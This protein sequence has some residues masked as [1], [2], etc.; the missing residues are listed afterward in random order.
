MPKCRESVCNFHQETHLIWFTY[1]T[2]PLT[3]P[4]PEQ[5]VWDNTPCVNPK[6]LEPPIKL[7][8]DGSGHQV[9]GVLGVQG[10]VGFGDVSILGLGSWTL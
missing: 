9:S 7:Q 5:H 4:G 2:L 10:S 8:F 6:S 3:N 1:W